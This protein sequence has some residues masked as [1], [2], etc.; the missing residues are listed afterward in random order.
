M[1]LSA[2]ACLILLTGGAQAQTEAEPLALPEEQGEARVEISTETTAVQPST[3]TILRK[4]TP[5]YL[6]NSPDLNAYY[7][8]ADGGMDANWFVGYSNCWIVK[9]PPAPV[10][11]FSKA[12][13]GA[14]LGRAKSTPKPDKPWELVPVQGKI[15]MA[16]ST[17]PA[18]TSQQ[19]YFLTENTDIPR[20]PTPKDSL[21][22]VGAAQWFWAE[23]PLSSIATDKPNYLALWSNS[24]AL[25]SASNSPIVAG[26]EMRNSPEQRVWVNSSTKGTPP[27]EADSSPGTSIGGMSPAM[28]IKLVPVNEARVI[29]R[30]LAL[31]PTSLGPV[32]TFSA[33][34][35][36]ISA[37]WFEIS[38]DRFSWARISR[39]YTTPP[40]SMTFTKAMLPTTDTYFIRA[41]A[42]DNLSNIGRSKELTISQKDLPN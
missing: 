5:A 28:V 16:L 8:Y 2:C 23:V 27:R 36:D 21:E 7:M 40:Y 11:R 3:A 1:A 10:G 31:T 35:Q 20:E 17:M 6:S 4:F 39:I 34:G 24:E 12:F 13:I 15:F 19:T 25:S 9:L 33:I 18:F 37:A 22:G 14:K 29:V 42:Q 38:P 26:G 30:A 41:V 32:A